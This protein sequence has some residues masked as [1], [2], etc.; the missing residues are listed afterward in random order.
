MATLVNNLDAQA[1]RRTDA[2]LALMKYCY[3]EEPLKTK[4]IQTARKTNPPPGPAPTTPAALE[5]KKMEQYK[6]PTF[7]KHMSVNKFRRCFLCVE[8]AFA[9]GRSHARFD[10]LCHQF[11]N[12]ATLARHFLCTHLDGLLDK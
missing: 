7:F 2:I 10:E 5:E 4:I 3:E 12:S 11:Y 8:M 1:K 6:R 9:L